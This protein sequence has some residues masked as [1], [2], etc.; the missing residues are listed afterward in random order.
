MIMGNPIREVQ[1]F[2]QSI[3]YDNIRRGVITSGELHSMVAN[4]GLLGVTSNPA[5]FKAAVVGS[6]DYDQAIK[7]EVRQGAITAQEVY[8]SL[9]VDDIRWACDVLYP[10]YAATKG[11]D[12]FVSLEVSP[13]LAN[14]TQATIVEARRLH[15]AVGRDNVMIKIPGTQAGA[16]AIEQMIS[17]GVNINVTLLFAVDAYINVAEAYMSGLEK[18]IAKGGDASQV[19]SVASF[20]VSRIDTL[21]DDRLAKMIASAKD[22]ATKA[23]MESLLGK[24]AI[25]NARLAYA[26]YL[27]MTS[28]ERWR[29]LA[30]HGAKTQRLL[31]A[32]TSTKNPKYPKTMYVDELIGADT[33][34]TI[35]AE[36]YH[37]FKE[38]GKVAAALTDNW[39]V[40]IKNAQET[41]ATLE[42]VGISMDEVTQTLLDEA[43]KKFTDPF[44]Q[45]LGALDVKL[46][47]QAAAVSASAKP[48]DKKLVGAK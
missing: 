16:P 6:T 12:G 37:A 34:N 14:D 18:F 42:E 8:E 7:A 46:K 36:T 9:A 4:D 45:L 30:S 24:V 1:K 43:I 32:S 38:S 31:W 15:R 2:G 23:K 20:F 21:I 19:N 40:G 3:W 22:A 48:A 44:D 11:R 17:E 35:P 39:A 13:Y 5:I 47:Q 26:R 27:E 33:V 10:A 29:A 41:M 28:G 25:A